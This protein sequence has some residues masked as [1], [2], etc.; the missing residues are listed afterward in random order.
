M[1]GHARLGLCTRRAAAPAA[2]NREGQLPL[3]LP[4]AEGGH[5]ET[6]RVPTTSGRHSHA[7]ISG[8][9]SNY[10]YYYGHASA[11]QMGLVA[12]LPPKLRPFFNGRTELCAVNWGWLRSPRVCPNRVC[13]QWHQPA[14]VFPRDPEVGEVKVNRYGADTVLVP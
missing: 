11:A 7:R 3:P 6:A 13:L 8:G 4:R 2:G 10:C 14:T 1:P 5:S 9:R 12:E